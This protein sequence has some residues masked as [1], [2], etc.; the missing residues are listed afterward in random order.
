MI[1]SRRGADD[2]GGSP[3]AVRSPDQV[4]ASSSP[5]SAR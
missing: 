1:F 2:V 3:V 4:N 5:V